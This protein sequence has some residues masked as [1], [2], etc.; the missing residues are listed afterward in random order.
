MLF[1]RDDFKH[2][3]REHDGLWILFS[4]GQF[5]KNIR[6]ECVVHMAKFN[7]AHQIGAYETRGPLPQW[8]MRTRGARYGLDGD[9][10]KTL[11]A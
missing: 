5:L 1:A 3:W 2:R 7:K 6:G 10:F 9:D 11:L 4:A 8:F